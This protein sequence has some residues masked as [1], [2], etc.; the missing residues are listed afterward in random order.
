MNTHGTAIPLTRLFLAIGLIVASVHLLMACESAPDQVD[1]MESDTVEQAAPEPVGYVGSDGVRRVTPEQA[2]MLVDQ[3]KAVLVDTRSSLAFIGAR[4]SGAILAS[5][6]D[7][8]QDRVGALAD[9]PEHKEL[10][11]Y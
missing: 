4:A 10:V 7:I 6:S 9:V 5:A 1:Q 2:K 3:D 8:Y 11:L